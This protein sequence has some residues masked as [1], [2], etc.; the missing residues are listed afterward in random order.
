MNVT[1]SVK[2]HLQEYK[3]ALYSFYGIMIGL[4]MITVA[5]ALVNADLGVSASGLEVASVIFLFVAG[6]NSFRVPF[7]FFLVNGV[8]RKTMFRS[9]VISFI[10]ISAIMAF[11]DTLSGLIFYRL[12]KYITLFEMPYGLRYGGEA[13]QYNPQFIFERLVWLFCL[14]V[15]AIMVGYFVTVLYYR[16]NM[17]WKYIVSIGVPA[18]FIFGLPIVNSAI[19]GRVSIFFVELFLK[20]MGLWNGRNP[21]PAM[22]SFICGTIFFAML[23][24]MLTRKAAIKKS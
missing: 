13:F 3:T 19:D 1:L 16:M 11:V 14:Y 8:S 2:Y 10:I 9:T 4:Q 15:L 17:A 5:P 22:L 6:L 21:Y 24:Y 20:I 23:G 18:F 7:L 12:A